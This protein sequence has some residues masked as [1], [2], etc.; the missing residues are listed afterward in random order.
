L[1]AGTGGRRK[2]VW[3]ITQISDGK[4]LEPDSQLGASTFR[5]GYDEERAWVISLIECRDARQGRN[6]LRQRLY[7][8]GSE[9]I[10]HEA[11]SGHVRARMSKAAD[12]SR[13]HGIGNPHN[14]DRDG[15]SGVL[16]GLGGWRVHSHYDVDSEAKEIGDQRRKTIAP[17]VSVPY[18]GDDALALDV[19]KPLE[20]IAKRLQQAGL[21]VLGED[22]HARH[23]ILSL[24]HNFERCNEDGD[25]DQEGPP[26]SHSMAS[27]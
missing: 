24:R 25:A 12:E 6:C 10:W 11:H 17:A 18:I 23:R 26:A 20:L 19:A 8:F 14:D 13:L 3:Q 15:F 16:G 2:R 7:R 4:T 22:A 1:S 9:D 5:L 21:Y 27:A